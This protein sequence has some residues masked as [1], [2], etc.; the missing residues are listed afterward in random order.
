V[1]SSSAIELAAPATLNLFLE[2]LGRRPDGYHELDSVFAEIDLHDTVRVE[3]SPALSLTVE[4]LPAPAGPENLAWRA[5]EALGVPARIHLVKRIPQGAGLG[6]GS[7]DAA[8]VLRGLGRGLPPERLHGIARSLGADVPFFLTGGTARCRGVGD[9]VEPL[10][11]GGGREFLLLLPDLHVSTAAVYAAGEPLLTGRRHK[12]TVFAQRYLHQAGRHGVPYFNRL[13]GAAESLVPELLEVREE[14]EGMFGVT[15]TMS[16]SGSAY[17][18]V[19]PAG[20][21]GL[22]ESFEA[23]GVR[24]S[25]RIVKTL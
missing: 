2:I 17:F 11:G 23:G 25:V 16:G 19:P 8:A 5:A 3:P 22:P 1:S 13:Q 12:S 9:L 14:A 10:E 18:A 6:G 24:V 4:G 15:F 20:G 7:S 21:P